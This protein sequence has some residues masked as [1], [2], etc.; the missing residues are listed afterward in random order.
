MESRMSFVFPSSLTLKQASHFFW[1]N[2]VAKNQN[3]T[4]LMV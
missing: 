3:F 2:T 1:V 4:V